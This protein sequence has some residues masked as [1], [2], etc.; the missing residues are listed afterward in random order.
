VQFRLAHAAHPDWSVA[1]EECLRQLSQA[2]AGE[3]ARG[4]NLG[5]V[6]VTDALAPHT[7]EIVATFKARTGVASWVGASAESVLATGTEYVE[8]A[9]LVVL[10]GRFAPGSYNVFS[11]TQRPPGRDTRNER[12]AQAAGAA[13]VHADPDTPDLPDLVVDMASKLA[14]GA[15]FGGVAGGR[16]GARLIADRVLT[17]GLSGV[18]FAT[19]V[20]LVTRVTQGVHPLLG[21]ESHRVTRATANLVVELDNRRA[22]DVL[23]EDARIREGVGASP[24]IDDAVQIRAQLQALGRRGLFVGIAPT[25][26]DKHRTA[27]VQPDYLVRHV[28]ALDP[29]RGT[30][31]IAGPIEAGHELRFCTRDDTAARKDLVRICAEIRDHLH[32]QQEARGRP[33]EPR[34]ALYFSCLGRGSHM[35]GEQG[36]ELRII[37]KQLGDLPLA[38]FFAN[39][40]IGGRSLYGYTGVL[41]VFY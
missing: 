12:G 18:V 34:G 13:L 29:G 5:F 14:S 41:T 21:A 17:G 36:E 3:R 28:L 32:E 31:A 39:G 19:D 8:E 1:V 20:D 22:F 9:A 30:V 16:S 7:E 2:P 23:L 6:Y 25:E 35:F 11:G 37:E 4:A 40:E 38:G 10:L 27:A 33:V 24:S 26:T 15:Q